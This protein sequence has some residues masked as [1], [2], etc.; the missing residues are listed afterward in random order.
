MKK[1]LLILSLFTAVS[2]SA[3]TSTEPKTAW[4][5]LL[6]GVQGNDQSIATVAYGTNQIYWL[7]TDGTNNK[8]RIVSYAGVDLYEG[9]MFENGTT[10][11]T[12]KNLTLLKTDANGEKQWCLYSEWGDFATGTEGGL[13]V[14]SNG[15]VVFSQIVR[16]T[17]GYFDHPVTIV[18]GKGNHTELLPWNISEKRWNQ[19]VVGTVSSDGEL[20]WVKVYAVDN[21]PA[22]AASGANADFTSD[23]VS[24]KGIVVDSQDNIYVYGSHSASITFPKSDNTSVEV[25]AK[26]VSSWNGASSGRPC[27]LFLVK[28]DENG[29]FLN[30]L[31][32]TGDEIKQ[33]VIENINFNDGKLYVVGN[34]VGADDKSISISG[35]NLGTTAMAS[36]MVG[37]VDTDLK[38]EWFKVYPNDGGATGGNAMQSCK[39]ALSKENVWI[40][41]V[42]NGSIQNQSDSKESIETVAKTTREGFILKLD[43]TTGNW[44]KAV[45]S[46]T[47]F[48]DKNLIAYTQLVLPESE[49]ENIY[50]YGYDM[51]GKKDIFL[52]CYSTDD[53][54]PSVDKSYSLVT[55]PG[56]L[57]CNT[58]CY[59]PE[60][61][62]LYLSARANKDMTPIGGETVSGI[63]GYTELLMR[64]NMPQGFTS[65]VADLYTEPATELNIVIGKGQIFVQNNGEKT[66]LFNVYD[67]AG[68]KVAS[69]TVEAGEFYTISLESGIYIVNGKKV[70]L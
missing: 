63:T 56:M 14:K 57:S 70:M 16:H 43:R 53:L 54:T 41:G 46:K 28:L 10:N 65:G 4:A 68:R 38:A 39:V 19:L 6:T 18:D 64:V 1:S 12:N 31:Q 66:Q 37:C 23:A 49:P 44:V 3:Q 20:K 26:N 52:R 36:L 47:A 59:V 2:I 40:S 61:A 17:Q 32:E 9:A 22:A 51:M 35:F 42:F 45:T 11:T 62:S 50:A 21:S 25:K 24:N 27:C 30:N 34:V 69:A 55:T 15:D 67:L 58:I 48:E 5:N 33:S 60:S 8:D 7:Q 13:A 29:Y